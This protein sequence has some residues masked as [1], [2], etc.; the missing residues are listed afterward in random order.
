MLSDE[1][2]EDIDGN[3]TTNLDIAAGPRR[4]SA[5]PSAIR[6]AVADAARPP[7]RKRKSLHSPL[8]RQQNDYCGRQNGA[9]LSHPVADP[10]HG[11]RLHGAADDSSPISVRSLVARRANAANCPRLL[12]LRVA[13]RAVRRRSHAQPGRP[14]VARPLVG[15]RHDTGKRSPPPMASASSGSSPI[16]FVSTSMMRRRA[17]RPSFRAPASGSRAFCPSRHGADILH[18]QAGGVGASSRRLRPTLASSPGRSRRHCAPPSR[19]A[20]TSSS[21]PATSTGKTTLTN[22]LLAEIADTNAA[23]YLLKILASSS[24]P[25]EPRRVAPPK[26]TSHR[27]R[28]LSA[29]R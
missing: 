28:I 12:D 27:S 15:W 2:A 10:L 20:R 23:S 24:A 21:R 7:S 8:L 14:V 4:P 6:G 25:P 17:C 9:A 18:S 3:G 1:I 19:S 11:S 29:P 26:T 5:Q 13:R 22:A 16:M